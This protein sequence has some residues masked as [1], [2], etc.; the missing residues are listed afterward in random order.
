MVEMTN[1]NRGQ[2]LREAVAKG[3]QEDWTETRLVAEIR[4]VKLRLIPCSKANVACVSL[5]E[6]S[7]WFSSRTARVIK[8]GNEYRVVVEEHR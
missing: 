7:I 3:N 4:N 8:V 2:L 5:S 1:W 6:N